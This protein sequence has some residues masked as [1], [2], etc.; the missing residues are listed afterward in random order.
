M[1]WKLWKKQTQEQTYK[2]CCECGKK[3]MRQTTLDEFFDITPREQEK[4]F[5]LPVKALTE[6]FGL[7]GKRRIYRRH[8]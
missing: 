4:L 1:K 5:P 2:A 7:E 8:F 6:T 3:M